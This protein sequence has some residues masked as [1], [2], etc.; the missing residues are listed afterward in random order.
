MLHPFDV[1]AGVAHVPA[2]LPD[3][4]D[5]AERLLAEFLQGSEKAHRGKVGAPIG[6]NNTAARPKDA[7]HFGGRFPAVREVMP[8]ADACHEIEMGVRIGQGTGFAVVEYGFS[9]ALF[10]GDFQHRRGRIDSVDL[11]VRVG[12]REFLEKSTGATAD[13]ERAVAAP[14]RKRQGRK[15]AADGTIDVMPP[16]PVICRGQILVLFDCRAVFRHWG[17][18]LIVGLWKR[19]LSVPGSLYSVSEWKNYGKPVELFLYP[20]NARF[21]DRASSE[22]RKDYG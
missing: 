13:F 8:G 4:E 7:G 17:I 12:R 1:N 10:P 18:I 16:A 19:N 20:G 11:Q 9:A 22:K 6:E 5:R 21:F 3:A 2:K 15:R 14:G